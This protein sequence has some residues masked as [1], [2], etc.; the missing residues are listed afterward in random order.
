MMTALV[1]TNVILDLLLLRY[2]W[3]IEADAV[4]NAVQARRLRGFISATTVTDIHYLTAR[5]VS[6]QAANEAVRRC[7]ASFTVVPV[8][9][10]ELG[11]ALGMS[12]PDFEDNVQIAAAMSARVDATVA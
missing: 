7:M 10:N 9:P 3:W 4:W 8:G 11:Q 5:A 1:D 6:R 2:P 12:G